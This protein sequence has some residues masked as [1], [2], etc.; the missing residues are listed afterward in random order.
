VTR[1]GVVHFGPGALHRAHQ[2]WFCDEMLARDP[3][4]TGVSLRTPGIRDAL[5]PQDGLAPEILRRTWRGSW[6]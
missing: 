6:L 3:G 4:L 5:A 2:A 1:V